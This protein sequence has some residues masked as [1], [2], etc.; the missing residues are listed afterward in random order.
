[1]EDTEELR[2][3]LALTEARKRQAIADLR[4]LK[5]QE[6]LATAIEE[7]KRD[8]H[9]KIV[10]GAILMAQIGRRFP[11]ERDRD[12]L[13]E[14]LNTRIELKDGTR[15]TIAELIAETAGER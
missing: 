1:M 11:T 13:L 15:P 3:Q 10:V 2:R 4:D 14:A 6:R 12:V 7:R 8:A 9:E 5:A